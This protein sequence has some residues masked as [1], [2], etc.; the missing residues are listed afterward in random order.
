MR[1]YIQLM[2]E[3]FRF[4]WEA[5]RSN[6]LRTIL[7][8]L[9]V[10]V[11]IFAIIAVF[12]LV[13]SMEKNVKDN[14]AFLGDRTM[15]VQ[16]WPFGFGGPYPWWKYVN[17]PSVN[18]A[19]YEFLSKRVTMAEAV[20]IFDQQ[21]GITMKNGSSSIGNITVLGVTESYQTI[22]EIPLGDGRFFNELESTAARQVAIIGAD[23]VD[24]LFPGIDPIG[25]TFKM[26]GL[27][28]VVIGTMK[29]QGESLLGG[30]DFDVACFVPYGTFDK[31]YHTKNSD[32]AICIRGLETDKGMEELE[33]EVTGL[34]RTRRSLKPIEE[35]S[36][37]INRTEQV[38][39]AVEGIFGALYTGGAVI[40][41]F[42]L[43]V[44]GFGIANIMFVSVR[45]RT[46]IIGIQKSLGAKNAFILY[47]FLFEAVFLSVLGGLA[48]LFLVFLL[49]FIPFGSL[50]LVMRAN[51]IILGIS[52]SAIIGT[53]AGIIPAAI[54]ARMDPVIAIRS[55]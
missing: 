42:S 3:S 41:F 37:S 49:T 30:P 44:G 4:A 13:D 28:F 26:D 6:L 53:L 27:N 11:G 17:R 33:A 55:K 31:L 29:K 50:E 48:G 36:F 19:E 7:S 34:M 1:I 21:G 16:K 51:N 38:V 24:A 39:A 12:V 40:S 32:P 15:Y 14:L 9:G 54:A 10:T 5:L 18:Y 35:D 43:L 8:L 46:N 52:V 23:I 22:V 2:F 47:Q 45:E 25:K 20:A